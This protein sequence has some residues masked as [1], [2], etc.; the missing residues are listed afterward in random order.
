[1]LEKKELS[2]ASWLHSKSRSS[3]INSVNEKISSETKEILFQDPNIDINYGYSFPG[4]NI[5]RQECLNEVRAFYNTNGYRPLVADIGAGFGSMSWKILV[6]G[7]KVDAFEIQKP[8]AEELSNRLKDMSPYFF[9]EDNVEE[10]F[11]V[12]V[13]NILNIIDKPE[14][15]EK[16]DY[17]WIGQFLHFLNPED[18]LRIKSI[19]NYILKPG[20][21]V[22]AETNCLSSFKVMDNYPILEATYNKSKQDGL[23]C[24]GFIAFNVCTLRDFFSR[25]LLKLTIV[26]AYSQNEMQNYSIPLKATSYVEGYIGSNNPLIP[27]YD[28]LQASNPFLERNEFGQIMNL[29]EVDSAKDF[30]EQDSSFKV[31]SYFFDPN[32]HQK[33]SINAKF[34]SAC[35]LGIYMQKQLTQPEKLNTDTKVDSLNSNVSQLSIFNAQSHLQLLSIIERDFNKPENQSFI[36]AIQEKK[37][38][39]ALRKACAVGNLDLIKIILKYKTNLNIE[40]NEKSSN[41][42]TA[43]DWINTNKIIDFLTKERILSLLTRYGAES[44][45]SKQES[46]NKPGSK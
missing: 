21:K 5:P 27:A 7:G 22:F 33:L 41:Q 18:T 11:N 38:S 12:F 42:F 6:A 46:K 25:R 24:P 4:L 31:E 3:L 35:G 16:Y 36:V 14:F 40:I 20:G 29:W 17:I 30:F 32:T 23:S 26:S 2:S 13:E 45:I 9:E 10:L 8:S 43:L 15:K 1:M 34:E 19:F 39:V 28:N 37:Y 44:G